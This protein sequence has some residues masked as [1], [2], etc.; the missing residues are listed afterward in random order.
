[1]D[2]GL[3]RYHRPGLPRP[4]RFTDHLLDQLIAGWAGLEPD[5]TVA[6]LGA[7]RRPSSAVELERRAAVVPRLAAVIR[8]SPRPRHGPAA[9]T[10]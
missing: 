1:M 10:A 3:A 9:L 2:T 8:S 7:L 5:G 6:L 4:D